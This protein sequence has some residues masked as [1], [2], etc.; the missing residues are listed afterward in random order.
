MFE[1]CLIPFLRPF[2]TMVVVT[3][4]LFKIKVINVK[5]TLTLTKVVHFQK[6]IATNK[7]HKKHSDHWLLTS[8]LPAGLSK[9]KHEKKTPL[10]EKKK[11]QFQQKKSTFWHYIFFLKGYFVYL[12]NTKYPLSTCLKLLTNYSYPLIFQ[13]PPILQNS[14]HL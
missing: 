1:L 8:V 5:V 11:A 12:L 6:L 7:P 10:S 13:K 2:D 4:I 3:L 14:K 9:E